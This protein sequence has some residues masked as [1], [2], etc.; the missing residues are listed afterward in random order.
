[1]AASST[2]SSDSSA[3]PRTPSARSTVSASAAQRVD[4]DR[5][6]ADLLVGDEHLERRPRRP[7]D[8]GA[9]SSG[10]G[11]ERRLGAGPSAR[12]RS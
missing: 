3:S 10:G 7:I 8:G 4:V 6:S 5:R 1:M 2:N 9:I 11:S 12:P